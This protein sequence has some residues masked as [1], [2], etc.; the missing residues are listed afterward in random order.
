MK[1]HFHWATIFAHSTKQIQLQTP[2]HGFFSQFQFLKKFTKFRVGFPYRKSLIHHYQ[3]NPIKL[4]VKACFSF[5][6]I[7]E[8][9]YVITLPL[10]GADILWILIFT[11][12]HGLT[13]FTCFHGQRDQRSGMFTNVKSHWKLI[14]IGSNVLH[15][16][17]KKV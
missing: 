9:V 4:C 11:R 1:G 7:S 14:T 10:D 17:R 8:P 6:E 15:K 3:Q 12:Q 13:H 5:G 2:T 16:R